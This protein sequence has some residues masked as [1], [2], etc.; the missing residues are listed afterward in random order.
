MLASAP[1]RMRDCTGMN[2]RAMARPAQRRKDRTPPPPIDAEALSALALRYVERF[3]T[4][5]AR[6]SRYLERKVRER[7]WGGAAPPDIA[8]LVERIAAAGYVDDA[9]FADARAR[10]MT[11]RGLGERRLV[12]QLRYDGLE[13]GD[14]EGALDIGAA[15]RTDSALDFAR[16]KR[17]GPWRASAVEDPALVKRQVAALIRAGHA[18]SLAWKIA[19]MP[20]G[21]DEQD[22]REQLEG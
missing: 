12:E 8:A 10:S 6:L 19:R 11:R 20:S 13:E 22:A 9:A 14:R 15:A 21:T 16:R 4:S 17:I 7:G 3:A 5:R 2:G 1:W 18:P